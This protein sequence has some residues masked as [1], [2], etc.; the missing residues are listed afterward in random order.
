MRA[1]AKGRVDVADFFSPARRVRRVDEETA[2]YGT[3]GLD[4]IRAVDAAIVHEHCYHL[5]I[6]GGRAGAKLRGI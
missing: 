1:V 4:D 2:V 3:E 5:C 6:V